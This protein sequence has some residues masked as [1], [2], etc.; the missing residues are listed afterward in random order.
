MRRARASGREVERVVIPYFGVVS[1]ERSRARALMVEREWRGRV[2]R[3]NL[4]GTD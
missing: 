4:M 2:R 1:I 3:W